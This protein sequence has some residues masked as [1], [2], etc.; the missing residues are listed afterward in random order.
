M[1]CQTP[2]SCDDPPAGHLLGVEGDRVEPAERG[3]GGGADAAESPRGH[4]EQLAASAGVEGAGPGDRVRR[5]GPP[6]F[7]QVPHHAL[8]EGLRQVG[9]GQRQG[10]E[11]VGRVVEEELPAADPRVDVQRRPGAPSR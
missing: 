8:P 5:G 6:L 10:A 9:L 2:G 1:P 11:G 7:G 3:A 4:V